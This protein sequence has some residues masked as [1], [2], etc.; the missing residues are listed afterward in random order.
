MHKGQ[1]V[2]AWK[3]GRPGLWRDSKIYS[4]YSGKG[5]K[6][7]KCKSNVIQLL[8]LKECPGYGVENGQERGN[9]V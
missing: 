3:V 1:R 9:S 8:F 2:M 5:L 4:K 7:L 6:D